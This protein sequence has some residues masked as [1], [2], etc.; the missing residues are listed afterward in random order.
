MVLLDLAV[1]VLPNPTLVVAAV[2]PDIKGRMVNNLQVVQGVPVFKYL[3]PSVIL[4]EYMDILQDQLFLEDGVSL[5]VA[6][7]VC[8]TIMDLAVEVVLIYQLMPWIL[9]GVLNL[10]MDIM[11]LVVEQILLLLGLDLKV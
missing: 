3:Q 6:V 2:V 4:R 10:P 9:D 1:V 7:V 5:V 11:V 8:A